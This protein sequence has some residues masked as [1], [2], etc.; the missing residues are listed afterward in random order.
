MRVMN[1]L[2]SLAL[3]LVLL[4]GGLLIAAE[5]VL[6]ALRRPALLIDRPGWYRALTTTHLGD[7][8]VRTVA[9]VVLLLG[10]SILLAQLRRWNPD[11]LAARFGGGWHLQVRSLERRLSVAANEVPGVTGA[12][13]RIRRHGAAWRPRIRAGG[14]PSARPAVE[15]AVRL[16]LD[17]LGAP[18]T[19]PAN[20]DLARRVR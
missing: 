17:R 18:P 16:A 14:D 20:V 3:A 13:A 1:R 2:A 15:T 7:P 12:R 5:A 9:I 10:L 19:E 8:V 11:R 6:V 4:A